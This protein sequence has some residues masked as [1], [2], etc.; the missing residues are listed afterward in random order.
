MMGQARQQRGTV[1]AV[2]AVCGLMFACPAHAAEPAPGEAL[3]A[4][5]FR[6]KTQELTDRCLA[7]IHTLQDW[8][9]RRDEYRRQLQ[10]MLGLFPWPEKTPLQPVITGTVE[11]TDFV[12]E[13]LHFQSLPGLYV[14]AN[15][16]RPRECPQPLPAI[17]YVCGHA[18][19]KEGDI[20]YGNKAGYQ[21]HGSWF[22][23]NGYVCLIIDTIQLGE[24]EGRHH[25]TYREGMW[26]WNSRGYTPA[27]V[28]AWNG[29]R[30]L[31][32]LQSRPEVDGQRIGM[33]G[34]SGGG[35]YS[36]WVSAL[37][38][39]IQC[40]VPVAGITSL[41]NHVVDGCVEGHCDCMYYVNTYGWDFPLVSALVAPRPLLITNTDKDRIFPLDGVVDVY[42]KTRR[43]YELYGA[44]DKLGLC[45]AEGP[46]K[47]IQEIQ[48]DAFHWMNRFL[49]AEDPPIEMAAKK[50]FAPA[51]LKVFGQLPA[52]EKVTSAHAWFVPTQA[53]E[54]LPESPA[55]FSHA[56]QEWSAFLLDQCFRGMNPQQLNTPPQVQLLGT[57]TS[58]SLRLRK[59]QFAGEAPYQLTFLVL[60]QGPT[61]AR[62]IHVQI[63]DQSE[64]DRQ[65]GSLKTRF[66]ELSETADRLEAQPP[67]LRLEPDSIMVF[68]APRG[69]GETAWSKD[70]RQETHIRRRFALLGT[71]EDRVRV[72]DTIRALAAIRATL[73]VPGAPLT[74]RGG[75]AAA[76]WALHAALFAPG[77]DRLQLEGL[78][79][80]YQQGP[81]LLN[82]QKQL[83]VPRTLLMV[84]SRVKTVQLLDDDPVHRALSHIV[85]AA[86]ASCGLTA[87]GL[88]Q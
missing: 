41:K 53:T 18:R 6:I 42:F 8:T 77:I 4:D 75:G 11:H 52:D 85:S 36:W 9:T 79:T 33:T 5:Y 29:I 40:A 31:D 59:F 82:I 7:D 65:I 26:W 67:P 13:K 73:D 16:Y 38:E 69:I 30:A 58:D 54:P 88:S 32:Y 81:F 87:G 86:A 14:T 34:R 22:A 35:A 60:D 20:S 66:A 63:C 61:A 27:G 44:E 24:I 64:W 74:V 62:Q 39:R 45:I 28:E 57:W 56:A 68:F 78:S 2:A 37:D 21:H 70:A 17:L 25:G 51:D 15:L 72:E 83:S 19:V 55:A 71:T 46:H 80:D 84:A 76:D 12:V 50:L 47:D 48:V 3:L 49:K 10:E 1:W 23:R 43:I